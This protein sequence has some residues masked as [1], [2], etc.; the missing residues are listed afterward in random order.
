[1]VVIHEGKNL[2]TCLG[3][4][5]GT[6]CEHRS[7]STQMRDNWEK[8]QLCYKCARLLHP[9]Y[10]EDKRHHGVK[11]YPKND[12]RYSKVPFNLVEEPTS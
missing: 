3:H 12:V 2:A 8:W 4:R 6:G 9:K 11:T 10:Y 7:R 1:L 5:F